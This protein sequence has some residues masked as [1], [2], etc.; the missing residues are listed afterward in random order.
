MREGLNYNAFK[1]YIENQEKKK[2]KEN[3]REKIL[4]EV[5]ENKKL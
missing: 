2:K 5:K 4:I 1:K 3:L